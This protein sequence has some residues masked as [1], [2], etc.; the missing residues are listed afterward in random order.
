MFG[1][2]KPHKEMASR[3]GTSVLWHRMY[4]GASSPWR[5]GSSW[6][7]LWDGEV[8]YADSLSASAAGRSSTSGHIAAGC[9]GWNR[10]GYNQIKS[11]QISTSSSSQS[12]TERPRLYSS[13]L[14]C[15]ASRFYFSSVHPAS[16]SYVTRRVSFALSNASRISIQLISH[17]LSPCDTRLF[18]LHL[19][20]YHPLLQIN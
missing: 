18:V 13:I 11:N 15:N 3:G 17:H 14:S 19:V 2:R 1:L 10:I 6:S 7:R 12:G 8:G 16:C 4:I 5:R 20:F 9:C